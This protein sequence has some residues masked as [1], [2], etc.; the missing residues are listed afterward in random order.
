M[1]FKCNYRFA[2]LNCT[3]SPFSCCSKIGRPPFSSKTSLLC[4]WAGFPL[5]MQFSKSKEVMGFKRPC[6]SRTSDHSPVSLVTL[7][8]SLTILQKMSSIST[9]VFFSL[10]CKLQGMI[11]STHSIMRGTHHCRG[12]I[13][14]RCSGKINST[15]SGKDNAHILKSSS[16][17]CLKLS[18]KH[19]LSFTSSS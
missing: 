10:G 4:I 19:S 17:S 8:G 14:S 18:F 15:F 16:T 7:K 13:P 11:N 2:W 1:V 6:L 12:K 5:D 9:F 3:F